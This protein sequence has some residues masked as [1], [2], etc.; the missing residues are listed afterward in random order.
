MAE[1]TTTATTA[2]EAP[3]AHVIEAIARVMRDMPPIGKNE[4]MT[5]GAQYRYRGIEAITAEAQRLCARH[6]VVIVPHV[7]D[8]SVKDYL[9]NGKPWTEDCL[10]ITYTV[11]GPG[12]I[13]DYIEAGPLIG[14]GRDNSDKG[15][16]KA[17][18]QAFKYCLMEL[19]Q[20]G[21][22]KD[23]ADS[24]HSETDAPGAPTK[25]EA[26]QAEI[27]AHEHGWDSDEHYQQTR[28]QTKNDLH[29]HTEAG[30]LTKEQG[31]DLWATWQTAVK[32]PAAH[33]AFVA[34]VTTAIQTGKTTSQPE[35]P[36]GPPEPPQPGRAASAPETAD[37]PDSDR[38]E[39]EYQRDNLDD[40]FADKGIDPM[41][42]AIAKLSPRAL[43][44]RLQRRGRSTNGNLDTLRK[45]LGTAIIKAD[46]DAKKQA[47]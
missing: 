27:W 23:D 11:Y 35:A 40:L 15:A 37:G 28:Q 17:E 6:G 45:R 16:N 2:T 41:I 29:A 4:Q 7:I 9:S 32:T 20:I 22:A 25:T 39:G 13:T 5:Q 19:F 21:D 26:E 1:Q 43:A 3:A 46:A 42:E 10:T 31:A 38:Q 33:E 44:E 14:L 30:E 8:R 36:T 18:T 24:S 47:L 12:G 34:Q